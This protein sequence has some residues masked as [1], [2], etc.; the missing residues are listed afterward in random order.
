MGR[1]TQDPELRYTSTGD[2]YLLTAIAVDRDYYTGDGQN[3]KRPVDF[4]SIKAWRKRAE[5]FAKYI[6]KG[7]LIVVN[8]RIEQVK[9]LDKNTNTVK[10]M[11]QVLLKEV[12]FASRKPLEAQQEAEKKQ[13]LPEMGFDFQKQMLDEVPFP[14]DAPPEKIDFVDRQEPPLGERVIDPHTI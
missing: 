9:Y 14:T 6:R 11:L 3:R 13:S 10:S 5:F 1:V 12:Y 4:I 7:D 8:G 2:A